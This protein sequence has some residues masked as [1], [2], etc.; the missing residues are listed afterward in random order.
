MS[1]L[2]SLTFCTAPQQIAENPR[3]I[4]RQKLIE[5]LEEQ[6]RLVKDPDYLVVVKRGSKD[7]EGNRVVTERTKRIR[8]WW[9]SDEL[10]NVVLTVRSGFRVL[11]FEKGKPGIVVGPMDK[12][13]GV[14]TT[15]VSAARAGELDPMLEQAKTAR[16]TPKKKAA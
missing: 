13:D 4:R 5:K 6:R 7:A 11:E 10:G 3:L 15:L 9:K 8:P 14:L 1:H 12:L 2:K 16:P